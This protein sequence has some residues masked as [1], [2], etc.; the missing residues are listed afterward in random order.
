MN[1]I[2]AITF[3][4]D[5]VYFPNG[6]SVF[7][8]SVCKLG[9]TETEVK[10]VFLKSDQMN[11]HYKTGNMTDNCFWSWAAKEWKLNKT[12]EEIMQLLIDSYDTDQN[13][14]KIVRQL[15]NNGYKTLICSNN[16]PARING[17]QKRFSFLADFDA[18]VFSYEVGVCKPDKKIFQ[19]LI[20]RVGIVPESIVFADD[21]PD[22][23]QGAQEVGITTI[24]YT[25]FE[26]FLEELRKKGVRI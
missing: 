4:L 10:R 15:R 11:K 12:P 25:T 18:S 5:G 16:F 13:V 24:V 19:E 20:L 26:G 21:N 23:I 9:V 8:N 2:E 7:M 1:R 14:V 17:L 3:D 22:N 6:K